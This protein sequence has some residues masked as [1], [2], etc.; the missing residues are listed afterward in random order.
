MVSTLMVIECGGMD[1]SFQFDRESE[2][3]KEFVINI[4]SFS[5]YDLGHVELKL[6]RIQRRQQRISGKNYRR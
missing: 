6:S 5:S 3:V 2:F 4:V 1:L